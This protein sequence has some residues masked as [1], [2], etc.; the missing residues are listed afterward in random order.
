MTLIEGKP[1]KAHNDA[2]GLIGRNV[3]ESPRHT[4]VEPKLDGARAICHIEDDGTVTITSRRLNK[5]GQFNR[6]TD[7]IP[8]IAEAL[9]KLGESVAFGGYSILDGEI[10][11]QD[12]E[13]FTLGRT[14]SVVGSS[15]ENAAKVQR[16]YGKA[17]LYLFDVQ[18]AGGFDLRGDSM[19]HRQLSLVD[20]V[21][22]IDSEYVKI[23]P[24]W[25]GCDVERRKEILAVCYEQ[26]FEGVVIKDPNAN[27]TASRAWLKIKQSETVDA[28]VIGWEYGKAGGKWADCIGALEVAVLNSATGELQAICT[29]VPGDDAKRAELSDQ[30]MPMVK[31]EIIASGIVVE[32]EMQGWSKG[33]RVRHPR[34][35]RYRLDRSE[36]NVVDFAEI[37]RI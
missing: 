9:A 19:E 1:P 24:Q 35:L 16:S 26:G 34:I 5:D 11:M 13:G 28:I 32:L 2:G 23:V 12:E 22:L 15:P 30:L 4:T 14:M 21:D 25:T 31:T 3:I 18:F 29:V 10:L 37:K 33:S 7:N 36:P 8:H 27:Y 17:V 20:I 6:F